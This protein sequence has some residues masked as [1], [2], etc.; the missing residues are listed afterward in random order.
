MNN[1]LVLALAF[2]IA[3]VSNALA[4][5]APNATEREAIEKVLRADGFSRWEEIEWDEDGHWEVDD[6]IDAN[7]RS[8]DLRLDRDLNIIERDD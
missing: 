3:L 8:W 7:G 1:K 4:D 2:T 6:A 5:R